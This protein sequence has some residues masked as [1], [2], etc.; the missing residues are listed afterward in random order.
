MVGWGSTSP[1]LTPGPE[2]PERVLVV[3]KVN[4]LDR[5]GD[6]L[7]D[8]EQVARHYIARRAV[9]EDNLLGLT[10]STNY[11]FYYQ[12]SGWT[13]FFDEVVTP[14]RQAL[15]LKG[16]GSIDHVLLC[17]QVPYIVDLTQLGLGKRAL[18]SLLADP[19]R[20]G[21][22]LT[23]DLPTYWA[24]NAY[25][26]PD[27]GYGPDL[28]RFHHGYHAGGQPMYLVSRLTGASADRAMELVERA[29]YAERYLA[30]SQS[31]PG[32][33][34]EAYLDTR[35][36]DYSESE[37]SAYPFGRQYYA[38]ADRGIAYARFFFEA[39]GLTVRWENTTND[40]AIGDPLAFFSDGQPATSA[41]NALLYAGWY[42]YGRYFDVY[43]WVPGAVAVDLNS[44]S[45][46]YLREMMPPAFLSSALDR[47]LTAGAGA[48]AEPYLNG[49]PYPE[50]LAYYLL[51][52]YTFGEAAMAATPG[53]RW[54][55]LAVG[56]PLY[57]PYRVTRSPSNDLEAPPVPELVIKGSGA[58]KLLYAGV[59]S[60]AQPELVRGSLEYGLAGSE[61]HSVK[62]EPA[63]RCQ[64]VFAPTGLAS[65]SFYRYIIRL[66]DPGGNETATDE[67]LLYTGSEGQA[68][69]AL[70]VTPS[71]MFD[72]ESFEAEILIGGAP[73]I[74][75]RVVGFSVSITVPHLDL[76]DYSLMP[77]WSAVAPHMSTSPDSQVVRIAVT[78][79][80]GLFSTGSYTLIARAHLRGGGTEVATA[81]FVIE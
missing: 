49:H 52:G 10:I 58:A 26:D 74:G 4:D 55:T 20:L 9:P 53:L 15:A 33:S 66:A 37:L 27:P 6:G 21:D 62:G 28:D 42:N 31:S 41:A 30:L 47:G 16:T 69:I 73:L 70:K 1:S 24:S 44:N 29:L 75:Q 43:D 11:E 46:R 65:R 40:K 77:Y 45:A 54:V 79:P 56:D 12:Q 63:W 3:F 14:L 61:E 17:Y 68:D 8:S 71:T 32:F 64:Q 13:D 51:Q 36:G 22:R 5:D 80:G 2:Q 39:A 25:F 18:D 78:V 19:Y 23:P 57:S 76:E 50:T 81:D 35:Y 60:A 7:G 34:G 59:G 72:G 38:E 48:I 67:N